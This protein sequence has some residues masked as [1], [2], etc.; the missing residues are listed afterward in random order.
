MKRLI[1]ALVLFCSFSLGISCNTAEKDAASHALADDASDWTKIKSAEFEM[2][3]PPAKD[4]AAY[5]RDFRKLHDYND[6]RND[7]DCRL[8]RTQR[9]PTFKAL[10]GKSSKLLTDE[11]I[12]RVEPL[13]ERVFK[14]SERVA[15]YFKGKFERPRPFTTDPELEPCVTKPEGAKSYPSSHA[16]VART[17]ACV[18]AMIFTD[19]TTEIMK[20][21]TYLGELRIIVGVHHPSDVAAGQKLGDDICQRL[22]SEE[23]FMSELET[24]KN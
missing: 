15:D 19:R 8:A 2:D 14:F 21:G 20:Y 9:F 5:K 13:L 22:K 3:D 7:E 6:S 24:V 16:A 10:F 23:S 12:E 4:S 17:G 1:R 18:L 11:E